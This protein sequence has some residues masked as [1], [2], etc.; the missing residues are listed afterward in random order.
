M[1]KATLIGKKLWPHLVRRVTKNIDNFVAAEKIFGLITC[2]QWLERG[3]HL[4]PR[5]KTVNPWGLFVKNLKSTWDLKHTKGSGDQGANLTSLLNIRS[6]WN[7]TPD[8]NKVF[9]TMIT[10]SFLPWYTAWTLWMKTHPRYQQRKI[11]WTWI[12][13]YLNLQNCLMY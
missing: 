3:G 12:L 13:G 1:N 7:A 6:F 4:Y 8:H 2:I 5:Y 10:I 9:I 11:S